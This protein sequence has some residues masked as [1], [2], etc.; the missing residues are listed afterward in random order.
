MAKMTSEQVD[1]F[2]GA[3]RIAKLVTLRADGAPTVV[4][5]WFEWSGGVA[6]IFT[7]QDS[8]KVKRIKADPR[9]ALSVEEG[10]GK[11][12][13]WVTV[14]GDASIMQSGGI[15]L[16]ARLARRYYSPEQAEKAITDW[17]RHADSLCVIE[18]KP[19]RI[20]TSAAAT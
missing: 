10:V 13:S 9:V 3:T 20:L 14:E 12:E 11:P 5:L 15:E 4:P 8:G 18:I 16:A 19:R 6:R 1:A 2:L 17:S 7:S